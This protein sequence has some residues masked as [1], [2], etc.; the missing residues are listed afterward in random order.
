MGPCNR[1]AKV[2]LALLLSNSFWG[3]GAVVGALG[4]STTHPLAFLTIRQYLSGLVL[5]MGASA[6]KES[7][8]TS[9]N[10]Q[11]KDEEAY[12]NDYTKLSKPGRTPSFDFK[13]HRKTFALL[14]L[15]LFGSQ[16]GFL[17]GITLAGPVTAGV[18]QPS[19]PIL[20]AFFCYIMGWEPW[21]SKRMIGVAMAF[22]GCII[23]VVLSPHAP[24][25]DADSGAS[26]SKSTLFWAGNFLF[27]INCLSD[28]SYVLVSKRLLDAFS[29]LMVTAV[30]YF[31]SATYMGIATIISLLVTSNSNYSMDNTKDP[32]WVWS[33]GSIL[34]PMD[35]LPAM[36]W[37]VFFSSAGAYGL[38]NWANQY[39]TGTLVMS[40]T[41]L[42]P[43]SAV[44]LTVILLALH[45]A[46]DC[47]NT[48]EDATGI[49]LTP[50]NMGTFC[51]MAGVGDLA[52]RVPK[53]KPS[54]DLVVKGRSDKRQSDNNSMANARF[55]D[56][57][58]SQSLGS[59]TTMTSLIDGFG[60]PSPIARTPVKRITSSCQLMDPSPTK[61]DAPP[62]I[63]QREPNGSI[64]SNLQSN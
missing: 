38:I 55:D 19:Q 14:G 13:T 26:V 25:E 59:A 16:F 21:N 4:M 27:F 35:A 46:R 48:A 33:H 31:V 20:M 5:L 57:C 47:A 10:S 43:V 36:I 39:A 61:C 52:P 6:T 9:K 1:K 23:M 8:N 30:S 41:V 56:G 37:F 49:C 51:G 63:P 28:P 53:R 34:P 62:T 3:I 7:P 29:P 58:S 12:P 44:V 11:L 24:D 50:P 64:D 2:H 22:C 42:Q 15:T 17:I 32:M 18:W 40:Y 45:T 60:D 54:R